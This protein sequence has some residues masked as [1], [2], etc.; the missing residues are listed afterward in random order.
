MGSTLKPL[1]FL[2]QLHRAC[3]GHRNGPKKGHEPADFSIL[4][5]LGNVAEH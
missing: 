4:L 3:R 5:L 1:K 2:M